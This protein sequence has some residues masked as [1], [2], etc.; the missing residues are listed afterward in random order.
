MHTDYC[1]PELSVADEPRVAEV[2]Q[3]RLWKVRVEVREEHI[4]RLEIAVRNAASVE[5]SESAEDL[6]YNEPRAALIEPTRSLKYAY[7]TWAWFIFGIRRL[8]DLVHS[9]TLRSTTR[10]RQPCPSM[11]CTV[12]VRCEV[13]FGGVNPLRSTVRVDLS[14]T[15]YVRL[16]FL[17]V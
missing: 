8:T 16:H 5:V 10:D 12:R 3:L 14:S 17:E 13:R 4:L 1:L 7:P 2:A 15:E 9:N 11:A 6:D